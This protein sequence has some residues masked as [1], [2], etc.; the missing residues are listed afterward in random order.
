MSR[1]NCYE[2]PSQAIVAHWWTRD[3]LPKLIAEGERARAQLAESLR[4]VKGAVEELERLTK[5]EA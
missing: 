5:G 1:P 4:V 2:I 3:T